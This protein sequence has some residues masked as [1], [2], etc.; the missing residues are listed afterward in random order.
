M[1]H[2]ELGYPYPDLSQM[3]LRWEGNT[4]KARDTG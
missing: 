2:P 3:Y 1:F 4:V